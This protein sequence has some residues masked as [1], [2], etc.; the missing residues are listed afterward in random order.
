MTIDKDAM[1]KN[2]VGHFNVE[3]IEYYKQVVKERTRIYLTGFSIGIAVSIG[4]LLLMKVL[5]DKMKFTNKY[6]INPWVISCTCVS[7]SYIIMY[8]YYTLYPKMDLMVVQLDKKDARLAWQEYYTTMKNKYHIS[9]LL[10]V[11]FSVLLNAGLC[12]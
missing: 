9:M 4:L 8:F 2:L 11:A 10:G 7:I 3:Q 1:T 5:I 6:K 12:R